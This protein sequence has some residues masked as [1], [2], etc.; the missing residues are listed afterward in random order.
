MWT[1]EDWTQH[2]FIPKHLLWYNIYVA[3]PKVDD[4]SFSKKFWIRFC[5]PH[6]QQFIE[7]MEPLEMENSSRRWR[8]GNMSCNKKELTPLSLLVLCIL[9]Y[10][11]RG[12]T[13]D[14]LSGN[15]AIS[16]DVIQS[17]FHHRRGVLFCNITTMLNLHPTVQR[18]VCTWMSMPLLVS[19]ELWV[20]QMGESKLQILSGTF[21]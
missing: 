10:L 8:K 2:P 15:T 3:H 12:W 7:L 6:Q 17:F 16:L 20:Q 14:E 4:E 13:F 5:L 11:A 1:N 18:Q 9:C 21:S 19:L